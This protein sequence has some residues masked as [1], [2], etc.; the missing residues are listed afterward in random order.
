MNILEKI[1]NYLMELIKGKSEWSGKFG[2]KAIRMG[3]DRNGLYFGEI[4]DEYGD[5]ESATSAKLRKEIEQWFLEH[6]IK[7]VQKLIS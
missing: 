3:M 2:K 4:K 6:G 7:N 5:V 1:D